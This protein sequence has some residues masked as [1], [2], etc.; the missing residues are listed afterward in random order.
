M[1]FL[2]FERLWSTQITFGLWE[3]TNIE[4]LRPILFLTKNGLWFSNVNF[5]MVLPKSFKN[6][7][8]FEIDGTS[9]FEVGKYIT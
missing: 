9:D 8:E 7:T 1:V 2:A 4:D 3:N 5:S 6:V